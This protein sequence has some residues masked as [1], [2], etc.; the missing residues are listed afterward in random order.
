MTRP[1]FAALVSRIRG[2][3]RVRF[4]GDTVTVR[5]GS[6]EQTWGIAGSGLDESKAW[7]VARYFERK[8]ALAVVS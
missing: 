3:L 4:S 8:R 2:S 6:R 7:A 5:D 1:E